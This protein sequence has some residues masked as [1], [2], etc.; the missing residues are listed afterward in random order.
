MTRQEKI[1]N[2]TTDLQ[3]NYG[4]S[5]D[6]A[7][8]LVMF[9]GSDCKGLNSKIRGKTLISEER[10][11]CGNLK[12]GLLKIQSTS[13]KII[14]RHLKFIDSQIEKVKNYFQTNAGKKIRFQEF[15][16]CSLR[17]C[18]TGD[19]NHHNWSMKISTNQPT[20]AKDIFCLWSKH[21][22]NDAEQEVLLLNDTCF[23]VISV[24]PDSNIKVFLKEIQSDLQI[25]SVPEF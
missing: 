14:Y 17:E 2:L 19:S 25:E 12:N 7:K 20:N 22:L 3:E 23:E 13:E 1:N 4:L 8:A 18:F 16:S 5:Q 9:K 15:Q 6:E 21:E 10:I 11:F 24:D